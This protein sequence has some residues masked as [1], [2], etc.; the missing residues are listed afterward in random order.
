MLHWDKTYS[1]LTDG[2]DENKKAKGTKQ[3]LKKEIL[4]FDDYK[5]SLKATQFQ[6]KANEWEKNKGCVI[7]L[8]ENHGEF[9]KKNKF[10]FKSQQRIRRE[11]YNVFTDE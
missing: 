7:G 6:N 4:E 10:L 3:C 11:N 5:H 9:A 1:Y 2:N 8:R